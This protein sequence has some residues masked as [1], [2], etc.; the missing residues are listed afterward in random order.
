MLIFIYLMIEKVNKAVNFPNCSSNIVPSLFKEI[1]SHVLK[2][3]N[4]QII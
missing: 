3:G 2:N 1:Q 4:L